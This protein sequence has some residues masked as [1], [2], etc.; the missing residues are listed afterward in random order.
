MWIEAEAITTNETVEVN[1]EKMR[2]GPA[3]LPET[4][5]HYV[6]RTRDSVLLDEA[7]DQEPFS[8]DPYILRSRSRSI[9]CLPLIKQT[10]LIGVLYLENG[11]A[12]HVFTAARI[13]LLRLVSIPSR[14]GPRERASLLGA[15]R[16]RGLPDP[17][18]APESDRQLLLASRH[19]RSHV[20]GG[21][22]S[23]LRL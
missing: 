16:R 17:S 23:H 1:R 22:L 12:S 13:A 18:T 6:I 4:V 10:Q 8:Q 11:L 9:L 5:V 3:A 20:F 2:V 15:S 7:M 19:G 21:T 14:N